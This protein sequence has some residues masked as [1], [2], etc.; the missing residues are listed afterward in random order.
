MLCYPHT[1]TKHPSLPQ[2]DHLIVEGAG[3]LDIRRADHLISD[4]QEFVALF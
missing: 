4:L 1:E 2:S 3:T